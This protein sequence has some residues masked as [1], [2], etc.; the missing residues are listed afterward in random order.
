MLDF[1]E[2]FYYNL[3]LTNLKLL[4]SNEEINQDNACANLFSDSVNSFETA[5]NSRHNIACARGGLS[6][7]IM[8]GK[9]PLWP[10]HTIRLDLH[11]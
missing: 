5:P 4:S 2:D 3:D 11:V 7:V 6:C 8:S 1:D 10:V 9:L